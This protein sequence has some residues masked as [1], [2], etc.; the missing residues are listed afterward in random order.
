MQGSLLSGKPHSLSTTKLLMLLHRLRLYKGGP[1]EH[2]PELHTDLSADIPT[3]TQAP[4]PCTSAY[5]ILSP[6]S[7]I[8]DREK[9]PNNAGEVEEN[10]QFPT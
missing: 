5:I 3:S 9:S 1:G 4:P 10:F 2:R 8:R 6:R 7:M